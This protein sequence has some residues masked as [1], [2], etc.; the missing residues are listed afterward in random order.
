MK[1]WVKVGLLAAF[2]LMGSIP[3]HSGSLWAKSPEK[4]LTI[5]DYGTL[6]TFDAAIVGNTQDVMLCRIIYQSLVRYIFNSPEIEGDLAKSWTISKDGL[7]YTF[8]LRDD[9][10]WHKGYG[11]FTAK[12]VK[13]TFDRVLDPKTG[14]PGRA[15]LVNE[16]KEVNVLDDYTVEFQ[17]KNPCAPFLHL[18]VGP[19][20]TGIVNQKAVEKFGKDYGRN[21]IGTGPYI[22]DSWT[23]EQVV[24]IANKDF[25]Q[26]EGPPKFD[27]IVYKIIPDVDTIVMALQKGDID[28]ICV[29]PREQ[30]VMDRL[31]ASGIKITNTSRPSCPHLF[32]NNKKKPFDDVR[33]RQAI[34]YALDKET[35]IKHV[36]SGMADGLESPVPKGL[37]GHAEEGIPRYGYNPERAKELLAQAGYPNGFEFNFDT[38]QSPTHLPLATAISDQLRKVNISAKLVVTDVATW[39][40]KIFKGTTD[41]TLNAISYTADPH[42]TLMRYY[43]SSSK[44]NT[45][46]YDR[47]DDLI[48]NSGRELNK[49]K[50]VETYYQLQKKFMEDVPSVP[51]L[52]I[53][54]PIAH[55]SNIS[56]V[57][58]K[59][60]LLGIDLYPIHPV[61]KK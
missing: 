51:L 33:V 31:K 3:I 7:V 15:E 26:R 49:K 19:R 28:M 8:K 5:G 11:K 18:L 22:F 4:V 52:M 24:F 57:A 32:M 38:S 61:E 12:D 39:W 42:S 40:S 14:A 6:G 56:G 9:V 21:P 59:E 16:I 34:A 53:Q 25:Q 47:I 41:F 50:R 10:N 2:I 1:R 13:Y 35:L 30:A 20:V 27:K 17:L 43:H 46:R 23:R 58:E 44:I 29:M 48:E 45:S 37:F 54:Y 36:L 60:Y 55:K